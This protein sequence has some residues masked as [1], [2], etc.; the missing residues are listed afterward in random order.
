[1]G[2][3][4]TSLLVAPK[5][6]NV[7]SAGKKPIENGIRPFIRLVARPLIATD[8]LLFEPK[9]H[10]SIDTKQDM[11]GVASYACGYTYSSYIQHTLMRGGK[12]QMKARSVQTN[13]YQFTLTAEHARL[14]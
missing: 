3:G 9:V 11:K 10:I 14:P 1:M 13:V 2:Y 6:H 5:T 12:L 7:T 4:A 8:C